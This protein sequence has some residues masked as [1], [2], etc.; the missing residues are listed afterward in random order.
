MAAM[1]CAVVERVGATENCAGRVTIS[2]T[3]ISTST[4]GSTPCRQTK[5]SRRPVA[6][7]LCRDHL[8]AETRWRAGG[9]TDA[10]PARRHL[11]ALLDAGVS[12]RAVH[13][14]SGVDHAALAHLIVGMPAAGTWP[15]GR[16]PAAASRRILEI[17]V[18]APAKSATVV[19]VTGTVRR[20][21]ALVAF[22]HA[23]ETLAA[24]LG[25]T[26]RY[27]RALLDGQYPVVHVDTARRAAALFDELQM[28]PGGSEAAR[29]EAAGRQWDPPLAWDEH[30]IDNPAAQPHRGRKAL[31]DE[32]YL[33][34]HAMGL[35]NEQIAGR[36][37]ITLE[38][39]GKQLQR[40]DMSERYS[41][42][43]R[44]QLS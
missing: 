43:T 12:L 34:L 27:L 30:T 1:T 28:V 21:Q 13:C 8:D 32:R 42:K 5:C 2:D 23:P 18:P 37:N 36:M 6:D 44:K 15:A 7:G 4:G 11:R 10:A 35:S 14:L 16:I 29:Q 26:D 41:T 24:Q 40:Y 39:L 3:E 33:E 25:V 20:M 38:S 9:Y 19:P 31:F 22:G 17:P